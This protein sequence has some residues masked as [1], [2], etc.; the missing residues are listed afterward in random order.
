MTRRCPTQGKVCYPSQG[1][2]IGSALKCSRRRG[3]A[4]RP[5]F[6]KECGSWHLSSKPA[7]AHVGHNTEAVA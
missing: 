4:L 2:A 7:W 6:H 3:V 5:Y 1:A